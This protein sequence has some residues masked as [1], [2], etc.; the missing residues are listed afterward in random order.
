[1][2]VLALAPCA[3]AQ[4]KT[5]ET[6][7]NLTGNLSAGY[8]DDYSNFAGSD[9]SIAFGGAADLF[10][11][12]YNPN[13]LSFEIQPFYNQSRVNSTFQS[14]TAS[15]GVSAGA[16]I[17][18]GSHYPGSIS[19]S[20]NLNSSGNFNVPGLA[21]YTTH[22]NNDTLAITWGVHLH[23]LPSLNFVFSN[24]N[25]DYSIYGAN[26]QGTL[27]FDMFSVTSAYQVAGFHLN[28]GYQH[29]DSKT[30]TP[31][32][33][34]GEP[35]QN[36]NTGA[37]SFFFGVGHNLPWHGSI[38]AGASRLDL[39]SDLGDTTSSDRYNTSIDTLTSSVSFAPLAHLSVG[40]STYYTDNLEGTLYNTLV[41]TGDN[42]LPSEAQQ[43]SNDLSLTG[44]ANYEMPAEHLNLNA[45]VERQQQTFL[46]ISFASD[47]YN[48]TAS[49]TNTLLGGSFTGVLG[50]TRTS[51]DTTH[52]STLGVNASVNYQHR[53]HRWNVAGGFSYSQGTQTALIAYTAS[54]YSYSG[55]LGRR[56]GRRSYWGAYASGA[57]SLLTDQPG[58][59]NSS[60]SYSTSLSVARFSLSGSYSVSSG[61]ALLTSTGLVATPVPLPVVN[62]ADVV[63]FNGR[64]YSAGL[65]A[66]PIR[67]M[68]LTALFAKALSDTQSNSISSNNNNENLNF[69]LTYNVRKLG[70]IA[71]YSR[72][73]QGF[74]ASGTP[75]TMVGSIYVG[76]SR[77][78]NF[79]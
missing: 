3:F 60:Q 32:F 27:H 37:N 12:Y 34:T 20:D 56:I 79:F 42:V 76:I 41:T 64:S 63:L 22:G 8:S 57:R 78:F 68:I 51:L 50:V 16:Q 58:S 17:F 69:L 77:S 24:S 65:G 52:Q 25:S 35:A 61:N 15:S 44:Y 70:F 31:E 73:V 40:G 55:N 14:L 59:A 72:L 62:P 33:L 48:G 74:S 75:P 19:F 36:S 49:Y 45:F 11:S 7:L 47:S 38:S 21:N 26:A 10:G 6:S 66:H 54:G 1:M 46:G 43:S 23:D 5:G 2:L 28:G 53:I 39:S 9:H 4:I 67:G 71:G 29:S 18:S 30:L 13:F